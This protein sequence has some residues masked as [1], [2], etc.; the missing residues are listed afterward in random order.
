MANRF[1]ILFFLLFFNGIVQCFGQNYSSAL[2]FT[3][4]L[5]GNQVSPNPVSTQ[6]KGVF[7]AR[8]DE[9]MDSFSLQITWDQAAMTATEV[10]IHEEEPGQNGPV[11]MDLTPYLEPGIIRARFGGD[12][13]PDFR[14]TKFIKERYYVEIRSVNNPF[15]EIRGQIRMES[16]PFYISDL[17][18]DKI[19][20]HDVSTDTLNS[21]GIAVL[22]FN[23]DSSSVFFEVFM[24]DLTSSVNGIYL[25]Y[26]KRETSGN[27][28]AD[29]SSLIAQAEYPNKFKGQLTVNPDFLDS[30]Q[31]NSGYV[32]ITT[33]NFPTGEMRGYFD[34]TYLGTFFDLD[35]TQILDPLPFPSESR[36]FGYMN[37]YPGM[38]SIYF[39]MLISNSYSG[40]KNAA[41]M[42]GWPN[43]NGDTLLN[44]N[45]FR[46]SQQYFGIWQDTN[47]YNPL[48]EEDILTLLKGECYVVFGS[49]LFDQGEIRGKFV[50]VV[51]EGFG[52]YGDENTLSSNIDPGVSMSGFASLDKMENSLFTNI[53]VFDTAQTLNQNTPFYTELPIV[54]SPISL[55]TLPQQSGIQY[56]GNWDE[57]T[58]PVSFSEYYKSQLFAD[59]LKLVIKFGTHLLVGT[60]SDQLQY[61]VFTSTNEIASIGFVK[62]YP[63]L[64]SEVFYIENNASS[65]LDIE[66][67]SL[68][69]MKIWGF[70]SLEG[71]TRIQIPGSEFPSGMFTLQISNPDFPELKKHFK[72]IKGF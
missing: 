2:F 60:V 24:N 43:E 42:I 31:E 64:F 18:G 55:F 29:I 45:S 51:R 71:N 53:I 35:T 65:S 13:F 11:V 63:T 44:I 47:S 34:K 1:S 48:D 46:R 40:A 36:G 61:P 56:F 59:S 28:L 70:K 68:T 54:A 26:G 4:I 57:N 9:N 50:P 14:K 69:G 6:A 15:G 7:W 33:T 17:K 21:Y 62:V 39:R 41:F 58:T 38:D 23:K 3:A 19:Y 49:T 12:D 30:L 20:P 10:F 25:H 22:R 52:I 16:N 72:I 37:I 66:I 5:E 27:L 8:W 32:E 67:F